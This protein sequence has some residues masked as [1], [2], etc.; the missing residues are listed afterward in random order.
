MDWSKLGRDVAMRLGDGPDDPDNQTPIDR[1]YRHRERWPGEP[2]GVRIY[3]GIE[4]IR[5]PS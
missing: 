4:Q 5:R 3:Q 2:L 1:A